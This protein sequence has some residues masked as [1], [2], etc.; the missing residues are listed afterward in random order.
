VLYQLSY[1]RIWFFMWGPVTTGPYTITV[2]K[3]LF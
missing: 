1:T 2:S 3:T